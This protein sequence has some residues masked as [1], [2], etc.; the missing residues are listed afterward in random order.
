MPETIEAQSAATVPSTGLAARLV[1]VLISPRATYAQVVT[2]PRWL[3]AMTVVLLVSVGATITFLS[4]DIG[5]QALLD[6]QVRSLESFGQ[7]VSDAQYQR[8]GQKTSSSA[9]VVAAAELAGLPVAALVVT[10]IARVA[11]SR[12]RDSHVTF[13]QLFA[14]VTHSGVIL[15]LQHLIVRPLD[16]AYESLSSPT[17]VAALLPFVDDATFFAR[18]LGAIDPFMIWWTVSLAIGLSVV[19]RRRTV[20]IAAMLFATYF[21]FAVTLALLKTVL[22]G[23]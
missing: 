10:A 21:A 2:Q 23:A 13:S 22:S 14:I 3:G 15:A 1:G 20:P 11:G 8:L 9:S 18:L 7:N 4:T 19:Y 6:Q 12:V 5:R 17:N 16:Y